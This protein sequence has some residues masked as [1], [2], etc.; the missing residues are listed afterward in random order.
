MINYVVKHNGKVDVKDFEIVDN[1][2]VGLNVDMF[3]SIDEIVYDIIS[4]RLADDDK[5]YFKGCSD[6]DLIME[7]LG[8]GMWI[9][10]TYALWDTNNPLTEVDPAPDSEKH[11]DNCSSTIMNLVRKTLNGDY[12]PDA[13]DTFKD[14]N[15][16]MQNLGGK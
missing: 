16:A 6:G 7:H 3:L 13:F 8:F 14:F 2:A 10:N 1:N 4:Q 11:P 9:R 5:L 12:V 15:D